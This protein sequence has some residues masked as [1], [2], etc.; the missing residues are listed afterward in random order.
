MSVGGFT[1]VSVIS[2]GA[3][4]CAPSGCGATPLARGAQAL[5][6]REG[7]VELDGRG[8]DEQ[9]LAAGLDGRGL[10]GR[11]LDGRGLDGRGAGRARAGLGGSGRAG[12]TG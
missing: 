11:G 4:T 3:A 5:A 2:P 7:L 1:V 6:E 12:G 10:D 8:L 9:R